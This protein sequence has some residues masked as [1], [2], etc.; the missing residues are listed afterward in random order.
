MKLL[1]YRKP[2]VRRMVGYSG[3]KLKL[4]RSL[5]VSQTEGWTKPSR[6]KQRAKYNLGLYTPAMRVV[7]NVAKGNY[8]SLFGL[9]R[10]K[11]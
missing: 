6:V 8:P 7:R 10:R 5:G 4:K 11:K 9:F 2:S 1:R 3:A